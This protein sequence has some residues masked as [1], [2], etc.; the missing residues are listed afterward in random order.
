MRQWAHFSLA[1]GLLWLPAAGF[2][3]AALEREP[4]GWARVY[5]ATLAAAPKLRVVGHG[6][7]TVDAGASRD[8]VYTVRVAGRGSG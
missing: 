8:V 1:C 7:V 3:Q 6:P 4:G 2:G 5:T